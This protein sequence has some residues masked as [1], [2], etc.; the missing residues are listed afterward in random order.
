MTGGTAQCTSIQ[1][2]H[3][4]HL[5]RCVGSEEGRLADAH[6]THNRRYLCIGIGSFV[7]LDTL[8]VPNGIQE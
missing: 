7:T 1:S 6:I 8:E 4:L 3:P 5:A 2:Q